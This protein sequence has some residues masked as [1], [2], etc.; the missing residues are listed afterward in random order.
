MSERV[1]HYLEQSGEPHP[2]SLVIRIIESLP[3][4]IAL[5]RRSPTVLAMAYYI[6][7]L[8]EGDPISQEEAAS[9]YGV[10]QQTVSNCLRAIVEKAPE[11]KEALKLGNKHRSLLAEIHSREEQLQHLEHQRREAKRRI[12]KL[13]NR[14]QQLRREREE[15]Q[16]KHP[17]KGEKPQ[18]WPEETTVQGTGTTTQ[19]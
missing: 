5:G 8:V 6:A 12:P 9:L 2:G 11:F 10:N 7:E 4:S 15:L 1:L 17:F 18:R 3:R 14:I 13:K 16:R 19:T